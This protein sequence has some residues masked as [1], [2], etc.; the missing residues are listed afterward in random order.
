MD[1]RPLQKHELSN[2]SQLN[3]ETLNKTCGLSASGHSRV[4]DRRV[5]EQQRL[6]E[7]EGLSFLSLLFIASELSPLL[8]WLPSLS[9]GRVGAG[10]WGSLGVELL[11]V[12]LAS[13]SLLGPFLVKKKAAAIS[14][15]CTADK[16]GLL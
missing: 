12:G 14:F 8:L 10:T 9:L 6:Q 2:S 13:H 5:K 3:Q 11:Q 4:G 7:A 15:L 1:Q 16:A